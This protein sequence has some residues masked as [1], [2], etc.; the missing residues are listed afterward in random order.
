MADDPLPIGLDKDYCTVLATEV[1]GE[2][3]CTGVVAEKADRAS[4]TGVAT[5]IGE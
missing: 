3:T 5:G 1:F 4:N 2:D